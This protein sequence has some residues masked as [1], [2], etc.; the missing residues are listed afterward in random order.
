MVADYISTS[1]SAEKAFPLFVVA[2]APNGTQLNEALFTLKAGLAA[3]G[4]THPASS[5]HLVFTHPALT[6]L[7]SAF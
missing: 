6:V 5:E 1:F 7:G 4:G 2:T 3:A